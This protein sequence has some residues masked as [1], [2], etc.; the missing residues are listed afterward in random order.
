MDYL[1]NTGVHFAIACEHPT[2]DGHVVND[3]VNTLRR[4]KSVRD[5]QTDLRVCAELQKDGS[6]SYLLVVNTHG[7]V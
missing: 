7:K 5:P 3:F 2:E 6:N 1:V 4:S